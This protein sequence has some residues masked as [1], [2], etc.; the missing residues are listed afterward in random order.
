MVPAISFAATTSVFSQA[1]VA[2]LPAAAKVNKA[3]TEFEAGETTELLE[4]ITNFISDKA[5]EEGEEEIDVPA[6]IEALGLK[7][8]TSYALN[9]H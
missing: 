3:A 7:S 2:E 1:P 6:I 8:I 9:H 5:K 4:K